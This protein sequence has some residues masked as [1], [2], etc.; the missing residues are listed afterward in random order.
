M[1]VVFQLLLLGSKRGRR[2]TD[3]GDSNRCRSTQPPMAGQASRTFSAPMRPRR[4][5]SNRRPALETVLHSL[6]VFRTRLWTAPAASRCCVQSVSLDAGRVVENWDVGGFGMLFERGVEM[7]RIEWTDVT[8]NPVT[9]CTK[10][11]R[12]CDHCYAERFADCVRVSN[13][14][15]HGGREL[16]RLPGAHEAQRTHEGLLAT[17]VWA[18]G[19]APT[20]GN[21]IL[22][23]TTI[24]PFSGRA[25]IPSGVECET[26]C[27][28]CV[29]HHCLASFPDN[30]NPTRSSR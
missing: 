5:I 30:R 12:G 10:L 25:C 21:Y 15:G 27:H 22:D 4:R 2:F 7:S 26:S 6:G 23:T 29:A 18:R 24:A 8:W 9:G 11:T 19:G 16:A 20:C 13:F 3:T 14:R 17:E 28:D 1:P